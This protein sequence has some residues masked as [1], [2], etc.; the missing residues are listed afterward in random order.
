MRL[1]FANVSFAVTSLDGCM[2]TLSIYLKSVHFK[3]PELHNPH[4]FQN[5]C[6][7]Q[8]NISWI[9]TKSADVKLKMTTI[10][11]EMRIASKS[12]WTLVQENWLTL[13][14]IAIINKI[15][16]KTTFIKKPKSIFKMN[17]LHLIMGLVNCPCRPRKLM[18]KAWPVSMSIY[19]NSFIYL[20]G[21]MQSVLSVEILQ[22]MA[23]NLQPK[24]GRECKTSNIKSL[25]TP[26]RSTTTG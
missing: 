15:S 6:H 5:R 17:E 21:D 3:N 26:A 20:V 19:L 11:K 4:F 7:F 9:K 18:I 14:I 16:L 12:E 23:S 22:I 8:Y 25:K 1:E 2:R 13:M 10:L 24:Q